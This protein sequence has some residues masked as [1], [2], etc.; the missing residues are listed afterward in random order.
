[1]SIEEKHT[2]LLKLL[3]DN[4][5]RLWQ[6]DRVELTEDELDIAIDQAEAKKAK[7]DARLASH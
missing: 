5:L 3:I 4:A 7:L 6:R 1:M 2:V